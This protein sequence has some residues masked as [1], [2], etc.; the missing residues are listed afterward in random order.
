MHPDPRVR[1]LALIVV[2]GLATGVLT[3]VGQS[4]L[5]DGWSQAANAITPWLI[6]AFLVGSR[7]PDRHWAAGAGAVTLVLA[8][9]GY[10]AMTELR[11]GIGGGTS[12][13]LFWGLG[14]IVGGPVFGVAGLAWHDGPVRQ[15]G[16]AIGLV[17]AVAI[18]EGLYHAVVLA[19][20]AV[21]A[22]FIVVGLVAPLVLGR[23]REERLT[24]YAATL[25][26]LALG[27]V[28]FAFFML[29]Y[30]RITGV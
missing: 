23:S 21:A 17:A 1:R 27:A 20:P 12:S 25:P 8:M 11:Y 24:G 15:R 19:E 30:E 7:M 26:G 18:A 6:V 4:V 5:P 3:Q 13:L 9:V 16:M 28:G 22:G 29:L 10:Y 2:A 14:A